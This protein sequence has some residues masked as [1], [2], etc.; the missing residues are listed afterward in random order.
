MGKIKTKKSFRLI[1]AYVLL[2]VLFLL[3]AMC[4]ADIELAFFDIAQH[5]HR[6]LQG[7][8]LHMNRCTIRV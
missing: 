2:A 7:M 5:K 8:I 3:G 4:I 6:S 1:P